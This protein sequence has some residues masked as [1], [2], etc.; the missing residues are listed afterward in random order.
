MSVRAAP[1][2]LHRVKRVAAFFA[3]VWG[4]AASFASFDLFFRGLSSRLMETGGVFES[5]APLSAL[6]NSEVCRVEPADSNSAD[7][8]ASPDIR[9]RA[10]ALGVQM[11]L[12]ARAALIV[13]ENTQ[14]SGER[15]SASLAGQRRA[16]AGVAA[17]LERLAAALNVPGPGAFTPANPTTVLIEFVPFV[18]GNENNTGKALAT[19]YG[20]DACELYKMGAY[21]GFSVL[22]RAM[23]PGEVNVFDGEIAYYARRLEIPESIWRPMVAR[24]PSNATS[25]AL[26]TEGDAATARVT[27]HLRND[28]ETGAAPA[29]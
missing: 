2:S 5:L 11:G 10:W 22:M 29:K 15:A 1:S 9:S 14:A 20:R 6:E 23:V 4:V 18:E 3:I 12:H 8:R 17:E 13:A 19:A 16:V 7:R 27:A 25:D 24:T 28:A 21:W 26:I